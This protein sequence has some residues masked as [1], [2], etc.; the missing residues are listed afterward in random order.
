MRRIVLVLA[1]L[2]TASAPALA[3]DSRVA[4]LQQATAA[5]DNFET[6]RALD[7]A[8]AALDP[9]LGAPDSSWVRSLHLLSQVLFENGSETDARTWARWGMRVNP[10]MRID[11]VNFLA[12]VVGILREARTKVGARSSSDDITRTV[13]LWPARGSS[14]TQGLVRLD[15]SPMSV[16][17]S[18]RVL[19][20]AGTDIG[21]LIAGPGLTLAPG[22]FEIQVSASGFLPARIS[23]EVLPGVT[24][25]LSFQLTSSAVVSGTIA[26]AARQAVYR[27]TAALSVARFGTPAPSCAAGAVTS[28]RLVLT[29]Y[30]AIR[31]GD[32]L[33]ASIGGAAVAGDLRVAAYDATSNL[34]VIYLPT[35]RTDSILLSSQIV[36]GQSVWGVGLAQC[37][38]PSDTRAAV[39]EWTQ[40][41]LGALRLSETVAQGVPGSPVVDYL[42]RLTGI[43]SGGTGAIAAPNAAALFDIAR[44]NITA[45][46]TLAV[47]EVARRENHIFGALAVSADVPGA[48]V[49]L[50]GLERWHWTAI[51]AGATG[52]APFNFNGPI[53][54]YRLETS[55]PGLTART[56]D[57]VIRAGETIRIAVPLRTV[58]AAPLGGPPPATVKKGGVPKWVWFAVIGG[59]AAAAAALGGGGGG[60]GGGTAPTTGSINISIPVNPP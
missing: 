32:N 16:P 44:R 59:G 48:S 49:R 20:E 47:N 11:S 28:G 36:D 7:L 10:Q 56:Q 12:G 2:L 22:T 53:G 29:S 41:P 38:T 26:D 57:V 23:R 45:Q 6:T 21:Q 51:T 24:M 35:A 19:S 46:Q 30:A 50:I 1:L 34:A 4:L 40:R 13:W 27:S 39:D 54:R 37:R 52:P 43:W 8:R 18:V 60:S 15:P 25:T 14:A 5:Y 31:G 58:A 42:G 9:A 33:T 55:A 3:Q 17:I